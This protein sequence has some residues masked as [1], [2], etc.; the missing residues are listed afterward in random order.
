[1]YHSTKFREDISNCGRIIAINVFYVFYKRRP[2]AILDFIRSEISK[3]IWFTDTDI[4]LCAK[5]HAIIGNSGW[6]MGVILTFQNALYKAHCQQR[7]NHSA[8]QLVPNMWNCVI[9][10]I[11]LFVL[12]QVGRCYTVRTENVKK[13]FRGQGGGGPRGALPP[14]FW[15]PPKTRIFDRTFEK[16]RFWKNF[17][18]HYND[19]SCGCRYAKCPNLTPRIPGCKKARGLKFTRSL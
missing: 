2:A 12:S 18:F 13:K 10:S 14:K 9:T 16:K 1:M 11:Y 17:F 3:Y 8:Y 15:V 6:V 4:S 5:Y 19:P 7:A